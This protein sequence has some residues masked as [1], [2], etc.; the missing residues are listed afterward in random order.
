M[1]TV[2]R[3]LIVLAFILLANNY[4]MSQI[5]IGELNKSWTFDQ[6]YLDSVRVYFT[7]MD[8]IEYT[9]L[10]DSRLKISN[11]FTNQAAYISWN[12]SSPDHILQHIN[13]S[14]SINESL[15]V[16]Y[17]DNQHLIY[18]KSDYNQALK[19]QIVIE[20]RLIPYNK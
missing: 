17:L 9:Y 8:S 1:T 13:S 10:S 2:K 11:K 4:G 5:N 14:G 3:I 6:V 15:Q 16:I 18:T 19:R 20:Y 7:Q 12:Y